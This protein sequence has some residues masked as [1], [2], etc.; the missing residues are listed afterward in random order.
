MSLADIAESVRYGYT[1]SASDREVGPK[2][3]RIT[4]IGPP[5]IDWA[6]VPYCEIDEK[7]LAKFSLEIDDIV[8]ART[9]ATVGYAKLI[10]DNEPSVFA[11]YLVR[12]RVDPEKA[13]PGYVG[14]IVESEV[15]KR[16][17][18]SRVGGAAQPNA[19][20]KVLSSFR[21][22]IPEKTTQCHIASILS[23]YD[24]L[25]ENNRRRIQLLEQAA[26]LLYKEWF[27]HLREHVTI[28]DGVPEGWENEGV[29]NLAGVKSGYA[30]KSKD[31]QQEGNPVIKI[32]N[33]VGDGTIDTSN[34]DCVSDNVAE[35][36]FNSTI[37]I[38]AL[39]IAMTGATV[40]KVGIMPNS[41]R[42][43]FL[44]QRVG[45]FK[46]KN[47]D[48]VERYLFPFFQ[49]G[50]AQTQVQNLAGGA[51][52]PNISGGQIESIELLVP[53]NKIL[54]L[55]MDS[56]KGIFQH[57]QNLLEQSEKLIQARDLLLPRLMNGE[58]A[59]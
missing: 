17:V 30:F 42:Q 14:R 20:A 18:L 51:A 16:F 6:S 15:Y 22:P 27:V 7:N 48:P 13:D 38:G 36:A 47:H 39:L 21:L 29:G 49:G 32:K 54:D 1:A 43:F 57:R 45:I 44:N 40:G 9:G 56:T 46:S 41:S 34:C 26:R 35:M 59:V 11:S 19:N 3:L 28:A 58:V 33:I 55:Y 50:F 8:I 10:R 5:Q 25:I 24:D 52:Q 53:E 31:W 23:A 2:F 12:I 37:P 4:D